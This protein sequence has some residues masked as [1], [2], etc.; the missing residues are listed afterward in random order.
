MSDEK[1]EPCPCGGTPELHH[2]QEGSGQH[3]NGPLN[4]RIECQ[5]CGVTLTVRSR[6]LHK[7]VKAW[8]TRSDPGYRAGVEA[9]IGIIT[10]RIDCLC[11]CATSG[12]ADTK[13][14]AEPRLAELRH[15]VK[16]LKELLP[17]EGGKEK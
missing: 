2:D 11:L 16:R 14:N 3:T 8:N 4:Y 15:V 10:P 5:A 17:G 9:A 1:L 13:Q 12:N 7:L 6:S